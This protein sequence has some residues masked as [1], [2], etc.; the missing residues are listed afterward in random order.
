V[1][2][3]DPATVAEERHDRMIAAFARAASSIAWQ[4]SL[5][6][7]L[8]Q[9]AEEARTVSGADMC[10]VSLGSRF[11]DTVEM[12]GAAGYPAEYRE[13]LGQTRLLGAPLLTVQAVRSGKAIIGD[14][15]ETMAHDP[16]F[17]P[18]VNVARNTGWSKLVALPLLVRGE[19]VGALTAF[20]AHGNEPSLSDVAFLTAMADHGAL[21]VQT[22]R[23]VAAAKDKAALEE[24]AHMAR[25]LHD[26]VSQLLFSMK[27]HASA[28]QLEADGR[29]PDVIKLSQ[30]LRVLQDLIGSAVDEMRTL[31]LHLRPTEL[32]DHA[33]VPALQR[34]AES[35][36]AREN[37]EVC[38]VADNAPAL[39]RPDDEH[40]YRIVQEAIGNSVNHAC[41]LHITVTL[42]V[43]TEAAGNSLLVE[44]TDDGHGFDS[45]VD[46][47]GHAGL[48]NMRARCRELGG[49]LAIDSGS[50]GTTVTVTI[51]IDDRFGS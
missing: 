5:Q 49:T 14:V 7:V 37:I 19:T 12:V 24:R 28:L 15:A 2:E 34:L 17:A 41:A 13:R 44:I 22:A 46:K 23:L 48:T 21:A 38:V 25:D 36:R 27:L 32:R 16:R 40:I 26:A 18:M 9:L 33:L 35:V 45:S 30:G 3:T 43:S 6:A 31:I 20:Y 51:P 10:A 50:S 39:P 8:D 42:S 11:G 29:Q 1:T 4:G 47:P